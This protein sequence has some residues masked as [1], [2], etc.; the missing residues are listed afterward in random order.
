MPYIKQED[1]ELYDERLDDL[2]FA[3]EEDGYDPGAV[4]Y[5]MYKLV[6]RW[7]EHNPKYKSIALIRGVL[8]GTISEFDRRIAAPYEDEKIKEN[9]DVDLEYTT[10]EFSKPV[11]DAENVSDCEVHNGNS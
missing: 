1:R 4:T 6:A 5:V 2:C 7:F 9:G 11:C 10:M 3:L 8:L